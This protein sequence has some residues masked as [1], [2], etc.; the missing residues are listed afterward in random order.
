LKK[1]TIAYKV[2][3]G[4]VNFLVS[5]LVKVNVTGFNNFDLNKQYVVVCNHT[6]WLDMLL[7]IAKLPKTFQPVLLAE[8]A[9]AYQQKLIKFAIDKSGLNI[10][11]VDRANQKSRMLG[12]RLILKK[13]KEGYP[14]VIFPEGR[15]NP[16]DSKLY[17]FYKGVFF[18]SVQTGLPILPV[19]VRGTKRIYFRRRIN[20]NYG[21]PIVVKKRDNVEEVAIK[22]YK[23]LLNNVQPAEPVNK[24]KKVKY[25]LT[26]A[27]LGELVDPPKD[28]HKMIADGREA[29]NL[30]KDV[31]QIS[32]DKFVKGE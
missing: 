14:I 30:F 4:I 28:A 23:H 21:T 3:K 26:R 13:A 25:D 18:T 1:P 10:I 22:T 5:I 8:Q 12:L 27:F 29:G 15:I 19:Y 6:S 7:I 11:E 17:P 2:F 24:R 16:D 31:N 20:M 32:K 9:G